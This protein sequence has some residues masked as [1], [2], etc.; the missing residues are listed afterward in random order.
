MGV[1]FLIVGGKFDDEEI[2]MD[3]WG[4]EVPQKV[5]LGLLMK[6]VGNVPT[7]LREQRINWEDPG[8]IAS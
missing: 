1:R 6:L 7:R 8:Y 5:L 4:S 2:G 3:E